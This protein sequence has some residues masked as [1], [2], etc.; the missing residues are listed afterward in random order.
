MIACG[1]LLLIFAARVVVGWISF[2]PVV[3]TLLGNLVMLYLLTVE[4]RLL[5]LLYYSNPDK[6][7]LI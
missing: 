4:M 7:G 1:G 5:G 6:F 2:I 3:G